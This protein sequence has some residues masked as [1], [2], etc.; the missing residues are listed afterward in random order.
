MRMRTRVRCVKRA[1]LLPPLPHIRLHTLVVR[2]QLGLHEHERGDA[3]HHLADVARLLGLEVAAEQSAL[4][5][6]EPLLDDL[7]AADRVAPHVRKH[8]APVRDIVEIDVETRLAEEDNQVSA[9]MPGNSTAR[10]V[11]FVRR[12]GPL[13]E[14]RGR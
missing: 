5:V 10:L 7:I 6:G 11:A 4:A 2:V 3:A 12:R 9:D 14:L 1:T 8:A 13:T